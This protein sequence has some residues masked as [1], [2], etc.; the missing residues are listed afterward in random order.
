MSAI[1]IRDWQQSDDVALLKILR[2]QMAEDPAWP[3]EYAHRLNLSDWLAGSADLGR[4]V[5]LGDQQV[6]GHIGLGAI[7]GRVAEVFSKA[8]GLPGDRFAELCRTVVDPNKRGLG[9]ASALTRQA[10]KSALRSGRIPVATVL[11]GRGAW[12]DM[13]LRTG[14]QQVGELEAKAPNERLVLL[15][16]PEKFVVSPEH[17]GR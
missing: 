4:W 8:T 13:M 16:A 14:W 17:D 1:A 3:P 12:L 15:L 5:V 2:E 6:V 11:T 7:Q 9:L 10:L